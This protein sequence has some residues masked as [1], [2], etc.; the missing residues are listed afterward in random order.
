MQILV[1]K[2]KITDPV[3]FIRRCGYGLI[4]DRRRGM[5]SFVH[6]LSRDLYPRF[7][8]YIEDRGESWLFNLHLDQRAAMYEG[9]KAH[10]GEYD[11]EVVEREVERIKNY[12]H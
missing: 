2:T 9:V 5:Q 10:S 11:G 8:V 3:Q 4:F 1:T 12:L 7:H 6:R